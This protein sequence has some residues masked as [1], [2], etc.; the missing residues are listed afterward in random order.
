MTSSDFATKSTNSGQTTLMSLADRLKLALSNSNPRKK[1]PSKEKAQSDNQF[2][3]ESPLNRRDENTISTGISLADRLISEVTQ[4]PQKKQTTSV[5]RQTFQNQQAFSLEITNSEPFIEE[6]TESTSG[7]MSLAE[8]LAQRQKV[9]PHDLAPRRSTASN[10][11]HSFNQTTFPSVSRQSTATNRLRFK[12][13]HNSNTGFA[14]R[15]TSGSSATDD[16]GRIAV[17]D[18]DD[19]PKIRLLS[20]KRTDSTSTKNPSMQRP[21]STTTTAPLSSQNVRLI[22]RFTFARQTSTSTQSPTTTT[23]ISTIPCPELQCLD[24]KCIRISQ[25]N[26]GVVDCSDGSDEEDFG[27]LIT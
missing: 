20:N 11:K 16:E 19:I 3:T 5:N 1:L 22:P 17:R 24:G 13:G 6:H 15:S 8:L 23:E 26:D 9:K 21:V 18:L 2:L 25:L 4:I 12:Q 7:V 10:K 27:G 14:G